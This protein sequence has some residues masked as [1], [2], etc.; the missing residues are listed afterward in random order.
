MFCRKLGK[1]KAETAR[2]LGVYK[3]GKPVVSKTKTTGNFGEF[4]AETAF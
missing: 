2:K 3:A 4:E 1:H